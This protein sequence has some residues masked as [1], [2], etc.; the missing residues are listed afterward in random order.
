MSDETHELY[1]ELSAAINDLGK[2][3]VKGL[4]SLRAVAG[5]NKADIERVEQRVEKLI[6][7]VE[8]LRR[9]EG[10]SEMQLK[11]L[12]ERLKKAEEAQ[13]KKAEQHGAM[14]VENT[15]GRWAF[16]VALV[17]GATGVLGAIANLIVHLV[18]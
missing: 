12:E 8:E 2:D 3:M 13:A 4:V 5:D 17:G 6:E 18:S 1:K 15:K 14:Q 7:K 9:K 10:I 16:W 11:Q